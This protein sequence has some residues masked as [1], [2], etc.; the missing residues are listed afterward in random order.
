MVG[1]P[2]Y[3]FLTHSWPQI[4][5]VAIVVA[6]AIPGLLLVGVLV[7]WL[8]QLK[9]PMVFRLALL[10]AIMLAATLVFMLAIM[11]SEAVFHA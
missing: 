8:E 11:L 7:G 6:I 5:R 9:W 10:M 3:W 1:V 4:G 2:V